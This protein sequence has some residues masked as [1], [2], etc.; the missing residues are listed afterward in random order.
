MNCFKRILKPH[1]ISCTCLWHH[2]LTY[3]VLLYAGWLLVCLLDTT[4][5]L[6]CGLIFFSLTR[7]V[8]RSRSWLQFISCSSILT[9]MVFLFILYDTYNL[10][11]RIKKST[12]SKCQSHQKFNEKNKTNRWIKSMHQW[13]NIN[14]YN[15]ID[16]SMARYSTFV[17]KCNSLR[18]FLFFIH[19]SKSK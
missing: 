7:L 5:L 3:A 13:W 16:K 15:E 9:E 11:M 2:V 4:Y 14:T 12:K 10:M 1:C 18:I 6:L 17:M 19:Q 8:G